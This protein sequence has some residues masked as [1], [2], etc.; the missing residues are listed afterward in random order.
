MFIF[1]CPIRLR[2]LNRIMSDQLMRI[3]HRN[4]ASRNNQIHFVYFSCARDM[5]LL[6]LSI[7]S[8]LAL[9]LSCIGKIF[10]V[11]DSKGP[12]SIDQRI[13]LQ[14]LGSP[15]EFL[16]FGKI[17]W[18]SLE[19]LRNEIR[20]FGI[21]ARDAAPSD[22]IAKVDSDILFFSG[23]KLEEICRSEADFI[24]DGHYSEYRYAQGGLYLMR[25][26]L[27]T[28]LAASVTELEIERAVD[29][30]GTHAEDQVISSLLMRRAQR[31]WLT[32]IMLFPNEFE[33]ANLRGRWLRSEFCSIHFV[34]LK[35]KMSRYAADIFRS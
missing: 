9:G 32:R 21:A 6:R 20:A 28:M 24:G 15:I 31:P 16:E 13:E 22:F 5:P 34:H 35:E 25:A 3:R 33:R 23:D 17:D 12:F 19:T 27:A 14:N 2:H 4:A 11:M 26:P 8:L 30:C 29:T 1:G 10:V 18:A 7:T